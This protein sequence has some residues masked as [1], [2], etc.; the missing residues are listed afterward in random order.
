MVQPRRFC[1]TGAVY[2]WQ[3]R[4]EFTS[5]ELVQEFGPITVQGFSLQREEKPSVP[6]GGIQRYK[7]T[8]MGNSGQRSE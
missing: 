2:V 6:G 7:Y 3:F 1:S 4:Q 5:S 8:D